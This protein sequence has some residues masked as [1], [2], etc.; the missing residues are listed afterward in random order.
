MVKRVFA[1]NCWYYKNPCPVSTRSIPSSPA[2]AARG[3]RAERGSIRIL[4]SVW[5][6]VEKQHASILGLFLRPRSTLVVVGGGRREGGGGG[7]GRG[8]L[9]R[10]DSQV[11]LIIKNHF[12]YNL[13]ESSIFSS[14]TDRRRREGAGNPRDLFSRKL[15]GGGR[16]VFT[17][18]SRHTYL[19]LKI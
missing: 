8:P 13:R 16:G 10:L 7:E 3:G 12:Q 9:R 2:T 1:A 11:F 4:D 15:R 17:R 18:A 14:V 6:Y 5:E 19:L